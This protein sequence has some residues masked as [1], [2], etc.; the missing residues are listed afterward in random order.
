MRQ[1]HN[2]T[3]RLRRPERR[4]TARDIAISPASSTL[5]ARTAHSVVRL[6]I[7]SCVG[8][9]LS[10]GRMIRGLDAYDLGYELSVILV[11]ELEEFVL[12]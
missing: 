10:P 11:H 8:D 7:A 9:D 4:V 5:Y 3:G 2:V 12:R 6:E 1:A